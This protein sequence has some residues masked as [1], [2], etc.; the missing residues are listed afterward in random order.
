MVHQLENKEWKG[1]EVLRVSWQTF[2]NAKVP[3]NWTVSPS[4]FKFEDVGD[5]FTLVNETTYS[6]TVSERLGSSDPLR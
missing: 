6:C 2:L 4:G 1:N 3:G 5:G